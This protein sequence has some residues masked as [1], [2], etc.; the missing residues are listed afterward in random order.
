RCSTSSGL[1]SFLPHAF[2]WAQESKNQPAAP[3]RWVTSGG[4]MAGRQITHDEVVGAPTPRPI[5]VVP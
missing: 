1:F 4:A 2:F 3:D 5:D